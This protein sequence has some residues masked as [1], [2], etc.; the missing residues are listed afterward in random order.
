MEYEP[1]TSEEVTKF[2]ANNRHNHTVTTYYLLLK[3]KLKLGIFSSSDICSP[4]FDR[5][6]LISKCEGVA[7]TNAS[8][9]STSKSLT[10][11]DQK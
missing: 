4:I 11:S 10:K 2:V 6:L 3:R 7:S 1:A 8:F 9:T 5:T